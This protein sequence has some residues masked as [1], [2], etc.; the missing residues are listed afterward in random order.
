MPPMPIS[1]AAAPLSP[2]PS[3][4]PSAASAP[5]TQSPETSAIQ[6]SAAHPCGA[7]TRTHYTHVVWIWMENKPF[8]SVIGNRS[9]P[10]ENS[11]AKSCGLAANYHG[12]THPSLPNYL[13]ATGGSAFG[14][15][16][17]AGPSSHP[18][19]APS[20]FGELD[21]AGLSWRSYE[22]SMPS[23]CDHA[24]AAPYAVKHN[25]AAY[26]TAIA[27][28]C[29]TDDVP[30]VGNL[31]RDLAA[32]TLPSFAFVTPNLCNDT[33]DCSVHTGDAWLAIWIPKILAGANYRDANTLVVLTWDEGV[34]S[35][36]QIPTIV[37][38]PTVPTGTQPAQ[39]FDHYAL[40]RTTEEL[41]GIGRLAAAASAPS[42]A[43]AFHL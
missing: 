18:I 26:F 5:A 8:G 34:G 10:Y 21:S 12:I 40:L 37:V 42:M 6:I 38:G 29:G 23:N 32:G 2:A 7:V 27:P 16:D 17:D 22:E 31:D 25:P 35:G 15:H 11:L 9:A 3:A 4:T 28:A 36:N 13:A 20:I 33:H 30:L 43:P 14:V 24:A 1:S 19:G 39:R 41:L